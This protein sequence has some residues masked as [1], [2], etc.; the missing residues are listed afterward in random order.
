MVVATMASVQVVF[1]WYQFSEQLLPGQA[2]KE[3]VAPPDI[4]QVNCLCSLLGMLPLPCYTCYR[5]MYAFVTCQ[6][7]SN[8]LHLTSTVHVC[9]H[10]LT[11]Y[12]QGVT[13]YRCM[14]AVT[15]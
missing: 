4:L 13:G 9:N 8:V 11:N 14:Y 1:G 12:V 3:G 10:Y 7:T 2:A 5:C 6:I 15:T